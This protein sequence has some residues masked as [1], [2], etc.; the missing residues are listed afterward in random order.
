MKV[1]P[2]I[3]D[4]RIDHAS[5]V[6]IGTFDGVHAGHLEIIR[7][8]TDQAKT[9]GMQSVILTFFPH[10][11]MVI[12]APG[13]IKLLNTLDER[14]ALLARTDLDHL[15]VHPFD[16]EFASLEPEAF[17]SEVLVKALKAKMVIV[18]HDHRFGKDRKAG[19]QDLVGF[20]SKHG[21]EVSQIEAEK[22]DN[23][24]VSSTKIR[25]ALELG[26][27]ALAN[28]YLGYPYRLTGQVV[29]GKQLGRTLGYPTANIKVAE[30][31]K[32]IPRHG[33]YLV[34]AQIDGVRRYGVMNIGTRPSVPGSGVS[35][36]VYFIDFTDDLYF[37]EL[38]LEILDWIRP[39]TK[40]GSIELLKEGIA[41]DVAIARKMI[42]RMGA[43]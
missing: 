30:D 14:I 16:S 1:H 35:I 20:G 28:R 10:P 24:A 39:E 12:G 27:I 23:V 25:T 32:L 34:R 9:S 36:E 37:Q 38:T 17:V 15:I 8:I 40:F 7:Q 2:S 26:D 18:G 21:F 29:K 6:T 13:G 43:G 19:Y 4:A 31:Y 5:V 42:E 33:V 3:H 22:I 11:R 41:A